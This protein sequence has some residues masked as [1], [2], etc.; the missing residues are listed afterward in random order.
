M[1]IVATIARRE[2]AERIKQRGWIIGTVI[3]VIVIVA[4]SFLP[5]ILLSLSGVFGGP[6]KL[7]VVTPDAK[8]ELAIKDA[9]VT[10]SGG[11]DVSFT[12]DEASGPSLPP[13][14]AARLRAGKFDAAL[15]AYREPDGDLAF[16]YYPRKS[17]ALGDTSGL[18]QQLLRAV[19]EADTNAATAAQIERRMNFHFSVQSL[20]ARYR[21][22]TE[23]GISQALSVFLLIVMYMAVILYGVTV[24]QGVIE[25]KSNRVM[26]LMI[27]ALRP[28]QLLAG[29]IIGIGLL[30]LTQFALFGLVGLIM[31]VVSGIITAHAIGIG[32]AAMASHAPTAPT[33]PFTSG[34]GVATVP[35]TTWVYLLVFFLLGF[36]TYSTLSAGIGA[37]ASRA[38]DVQGA[39]SLFTMPMVAAYFISF[40]AINDPEKPFVIWASMIPLLSPMVMFTR[41]SAGTVP[42][43]QI[44][45]SIALSL[46]AIW[47]LTLFAGK[48][49][50]VGVLMYGKPPRPADIWR[51]L[52]SP[53]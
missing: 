47:L 4:L 37:L 15:V 25:E 32:A 42:A 2:Y 19:L 7:A 22:A 52:R 5:A 48:L 26:E 41:I 33:N 36:F 24:A 51:A 12:S 9:L 11:Y 38:E 35:W 8:A 44:I 49:Y 21:N 13:R 6:T 3:G 50:R 46:V 23:E 39:S 14:V 40:F 27:A 18:R 45:T 43:W 17:S 16:R 31:L 1:S 53:A 10:K 34:A 28:A 29:K 20:N 30:A